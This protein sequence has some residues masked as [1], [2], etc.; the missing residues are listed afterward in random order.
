VLRDEATQLLPLVQSPLAR[1]FLAAVPD[2]SAAPGTRTVFY[3]RDTR[4]ALSAA[5]AESRSDSAPAGYQK[6]ELDEHF[7]YY[8][9][10]G[11]PLASVRALD[12][13]GQ[14]AAER[15]G[16]RVFDFGFGI[17][18]PSARGGAD[19][20]GQGTGSLSKLYASRGHGCGAACRRQALGPPVLE[21]RPH[22][23][24][25]ALRRVSA[26]SVVARVAAAT[27]FVS[28]NTLKRH[29]PGDVD[30][31]SSCTWARCDLRAVYGLRGRRLLHD[32]QPESARSKPDEP[33][34]RRSDGRS[35]FARVARK[36]SVLAFDQDDTVAH[37]ERW[38]G[39]RHEPGE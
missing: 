1:A 7:Y 24:A 8:T 34:K 3:N 11:T 31:N 10:Y 33:Y 19:V 6:R 37:S 28:K 29:V 22:P 4:D 26:D 13:V 18:Q 2:L 21:P 12:L 32:L 14:A 23:A 16:R 39:R 9:K 25:S 30:P 38:L 35:P 36:G 15:E 20:T 5:E 27:L 17:G